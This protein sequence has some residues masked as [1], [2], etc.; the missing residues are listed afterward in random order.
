M[1]SWLKRKFNRVRNVRKLN[2][3]FKSFRQSSRSSA[4]EERIPGLKIKYLTAGEF[5]IGIE[6]QCRGDLVM[7]WKNQQPILSGVDQSYQYGDMLGYNDVVWEPEDLNQLYLI[8][9]QIKPAPLRNF[10]C[11]HGQIKYASCDKCHHKLT[12]QFT[13][14]SVGDIIS[15][16]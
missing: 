6:R 2:L 15:L 8:R 16:S 4:F 11:M 9:D 7:I 14:K 13:F 3:V 12:M 1:I 10:T 5:T